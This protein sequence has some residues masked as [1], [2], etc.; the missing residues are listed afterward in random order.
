MLTRNSLALALLAVSLTA[1][2]TD[3]SSPEATTDDTNGLT[4]EEIAVLRQ[5]A[6]EDVKAAQDREF[7]ARMS[8]Q[9][10]RA[11]AYLDQQVI[12]DFDRALRATANVDY[13]TLKAEIDE[14][15]QL[16]DPEAIKTRLDQFFAEH[17]A[18]IDAALATMGT[19][20]AQVAENIRQ[21]AIAGDVVAAPA[22]MPRERGKCIPGV[23]L[24]QTP[25]FA[26][27]GTF[28]NGTSL[29]GGTASVSGA[30]TASASV[31]AGW[32]NGGAWV[33][34]D[35]LPPVGNGW[36]VVTTQANF[37]SLG[38]NLLLWAPAYSGAGVGLTIEMYAG[39][40]QGPLIGSC[41]LPILDRSI[42][43][44]V[45]SVSESEPLLYQCILHHGP[46]PF[47]TTKV[48]V[49]AYAVHTAPW[50]G[51]ASSFA[52]GNITS[53]FHDTCLD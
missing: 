20:S 17:G 21:A 6:P 38:V 31:V 53:I 42:P 44:G 30:F 35:N 3:E 7:A 16:T 52:Q 25:P 13:A 51:G 5:P 11:Q 22:E 23:Q 46:T 41:R 40:P 28:S 10:D 37:S 32:G 34:A 27:A 18:Q 36:T 49:D 43:I 2:A 39:G 24:S 26:D 1:C 50:A 47:I 45:L 14:T 8:V 12:P 33:R 19:T 29:G 48:L 4:A 15:L 9:A